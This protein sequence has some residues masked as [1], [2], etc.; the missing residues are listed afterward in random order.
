MVAG[1]LVRV[2]AIGAQSTGWAIELVAPITIENTLSK[3]DSSAL[4][5]CKQTRKTGEQVGQDIR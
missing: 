2:M 4:Q 1:K 3:F 5:Q